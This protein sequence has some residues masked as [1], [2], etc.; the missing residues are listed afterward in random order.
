MTS[1]AL[2]MPPSQLERLDRFA[3]GLRKGRD[4]AAAQL[5][6]E[7]LRHEEFPAVEFRD[8]IAGRQAY[9]VGSGLAVWEVVMIA[10]GSGSIRVKRRRISGG[11]RVW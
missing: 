3:G 8:S 2:R 9:A 11:T 4:E 5:I 1:I 7:A 6:E 10:E